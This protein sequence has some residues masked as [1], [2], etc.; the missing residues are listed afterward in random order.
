MYKFVG[1]YPIGFID[2]WGLKWDLSK[3]VHYENLVA[4]KLGEPIRYSY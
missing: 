3:A 2:K 4:K 1:N